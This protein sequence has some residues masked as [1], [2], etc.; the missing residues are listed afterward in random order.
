M[1]GFEINYE[2]L[3]ERGVYNYI[4][5]HYWEM[6]KEQLSSV[7]KELSFALGACLDNKISKGKMEK[8]IEASMIEELIDREV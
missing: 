8:E 4:D 2:E 1:S 7:C 3:R 6:S 5:S